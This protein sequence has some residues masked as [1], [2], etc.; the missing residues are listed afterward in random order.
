MQRPQKQTVTL[1]DIVIT[2]ELSCRNLRAE[3]LLKENQALHALAR[4]LVNQPSTMLQNI[5]DIVLELCDAGTAGVSLLEITPTGE[6]VFRAHVLAGALVKYVDG[7]TKR[8]FSPCGVCLERGTPQLY[9]YPDRYFTD[10]PAANTA[11]VEELV[12]PIIADN[13][14]LGTIWMMSHDEQRQFDSEDVRIMT[15]LAD[16]A[17]A[18]LLLNQRQTHQLLAKNAQLEAEVGDRQRKEAAWHESEEYL[19][20]MIENLPGGAVFVVDGDL[21]YL[22][23]EGEALSAAE[24]KSEDFV[25]KTIFEVLPPELAAYYETFYRRGLAGEPFE[26]EHNAHNRSFISRGT[27]LRS[28]E[29]EVYAV[30]AVSYD[31]SDRKRAEVALRES[32]ERLNIAIEAAQ[33]GV[34]NWD[35]VN[36]IATR[37]LRHDKIFGYETLQAEWGEKIVKRHVLEADHE[38]FDA[39]IACARKTGELEFDVRVCWSDGSIH[40]IADRGR[41][42]FDEDGNAVRAAGVTFDITDRKLAEAARR[43]SEARLAADL[44]GMRRLYDL[45]AKLAIETDLHAALEEIVA[46]AIEFT[47]TDRGCVQLVSDDGD[48]LEMFAWRGYDE[49]SVF[50]EHFRHEGSKVACDMARQHD[51]RLIIEDTETFAPLVGTRD[52]EVALAENIRATHSTP[53]VTR[54]G[55]LVGVLS[56]QFPKPHRPSDDELRLVDLLAWTAADF[57]ARHRAEDDRKRAEEAMWAFFSNVSHEFRTPLTLLLSSI[58]ETLSNLAHPLCSAQ[59]SQLQLA[60]RNAMRLLK[61]VNTLLDVSRIEAGRIQAVYEPTNLATLTTALASAFESAIEQAGLRLVIDC[62]PLPEP[63]YVDRFMWEKIVLNLLSNAF[64][65]T[66]AGEITVR[67]MSARDSVELTVQ[68]TGIGIAAAEL[69][70]LFERFYQVKK[71][72][73]RSFE[74][75]GIGLSLVQ[76]LVKL[77]GGTIT[78]SSVAGE[79]SCFQVSIPIGF[80]HLPQQQIGSPQTLSATA[81]DVTAYV[82]EALGWLPEE[83][84]EQGSRGAGEKRASNSPLP[85]YSSAPVSSS[86]RILLVDDNADMR[87]YLKRLLNQRWQVET[88]ANGADALSLIQQQPPDLVLTDVMMPQMDGLQLLQA[89][90]ADVQ[91]KSIPI[92]LLSARATEE[93]TLEGLAAGA[94]DYL[95][96]PFSARELMARVETQL[97]MSRL[98]FEQSANRF[99][100]EFLMTVTHELQAPLG[101][102]LGWSRL[103]LSKNLDPKTTRA[104]AT[105]ERNATIEAKLVQDLLDV[106]SILAG[107]FSLKF[108]RVELIPLVQ[109]VVTAFLQA[110]QAK[111]IQLMETISDLTQGNI[112]ADPERLRQVISNLLDNAIKFTPLG[113]RIEVRVEQVE[114]QE[115]LDHSPTYAQITVTDTGIGIPCDFLPYV[116]ERFSQAEV[117][118]RHS[119]GGVGIGLAIAR[120]LVELHSGTIEAASSGVGQGATFTVK[121]PLMMSVESP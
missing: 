93:A 108:Q 92:I 5:V 9:S 17:A 32:Q 8:N 36:D 76:E 37:S 13:H 27:P 78:V 11:I 111:S 57:I 40:W 41:F 72:R 80:A 65:F 48:R 94:D 86:A 73:R 7:T 16:F 90:R 21:R 54:Q 71:A 56:T 88:A 87:A 114:N 15:S 77:H 74:G 85:L 107:K 19:R 66:F 44:V 49:D 75:S 24:F 79:G 113:G 61:L 62:P 82:E 58:Q 100:N 33:M 39:A 6:E 29:G 116:F 67:L 1:E 70:R 99:K 117:P 109:S 46:A 84:G 38:I 69:P 59:R 53:L 81:T 106:S 91:T 96:K 30:L 4:Q 89:L 102:I 104:L 18:A 2:E 43:E 105:I 120:H 26:H 98:R 97:Q 12:L 3:N 51:K 55:E 42:Y 121:L 110:D 60:H 115:M 25:G 34:W 118:S 31:I 10:L 22:L 45:H 20:V 83:A 119:P 68:D 95:F 23:A 14:A 112:L 52:R 101:T 63:V 64:K 50:I 35:I 28:T 103:L 47:H